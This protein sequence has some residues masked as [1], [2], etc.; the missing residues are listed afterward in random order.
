V[1]TDFKVFK[2]KVPIIFF[3][4]QGFSARRV[5]RHAGIDVSRSAVVPQI[6]VVRRTA[7]QNYTSYHDYTVKPDYVAKI[8][9][10]PSTLHCTAKIDCFAKPHMPRQIDP[11]NLAMHR[12]P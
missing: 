11:Q 10:L 5:F 12:K 8:N 6:Q 2:V 3:G 4:T 1:C 7:L 9:Q